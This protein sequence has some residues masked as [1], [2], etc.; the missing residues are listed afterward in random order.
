MA[1]IG[2]TPGVSSQRF[3]NTYNLTASTTT[4]TPSNGYALGYVD[5]YL[6]GVK[7]VAGTDFT[8]ADGNY[9]T[10]TD[11]ALSGDVVEIVSFKPRGLSDGY[12]KA[13]A[14][15]KY[16]NITDSTFTK[17]AEVPTGTTAQRPTSPSTGMFRFNTSLQSFEGYNGSVWGSVG[18][19]ATGSAGEQVFYLNEQQVD[20]NYTVPT[21]YNAGSFGA[22]TVATGVSVTIPT[23]ST[24][25]IV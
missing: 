3:V 18:G 23:G 17:S 13:E 4:F 8:A 21:G 12:T 1:Y 25:T 6:N 19:G 16:V 5:V 20:N 24:W 7:L 9:V 10:L 22:V 2:N 15:A 11:A 14:N